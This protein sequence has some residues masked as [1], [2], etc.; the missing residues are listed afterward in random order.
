MTLDIWR[1][2]FRDLNLDDMRWSVDA[3]EILWQLFVN[4]LLTSV[5]S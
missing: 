5:T 3:F 1:L 2:E 4:T